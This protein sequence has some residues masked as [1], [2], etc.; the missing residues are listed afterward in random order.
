MRL[1]EHSDFQDAVKA[2]ENYFARPG[3]TAQFIEKDYYVTEV[4]RIVAL[5][6]PTQVIFKGGTSLA[7]GWKLIERFSEDIDLFLN[8]DAFNPRLSNTKVDWELTALENSVSQHPGLTFKDKKYK[9]GVYRHSFFNY[10]QQFSGNSAISNRIFLEIGTRSGIYPQENILLSSY[11]AKFLQEIGET[12]EAEDELPFPMQLLHF[13]RTFVEKL[14]A[15]D[16]KVVSYKKQQEP[17]GT[18]AR[19]YYDLFQLAQK[20]EVQKMLNSE[21]YSEIRQDCHNISQQHFPN[22]SPPEDIK[23]SKSEALFPT[24][25]LRQMLIKEYNKQCSTL[26]YAEY[27]TW[28]Q[29]ESYFEG[30]RDLL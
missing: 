13:R 29:I 10:V 7:K 1:F 19:H 5:L 11:I 2:A 21:E 25:E 18:S 27:P 28:D 22:Y 15:I 3:L 9:K 14:F 4:L 16:S 24:G 23:F 17:I 8:R 26:C 12:L 20:N 6:Y 30:L